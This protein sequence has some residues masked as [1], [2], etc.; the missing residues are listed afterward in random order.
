MP[1][2]SAQ[3]SEIDDADAE[4]GE[5]HHTGTEG[6]RQS[7]VDSPDE[8]LARYPSLGGLESPCEELNR[9]DQVEQ[10]YRVMMIV[11]FWNVA[12]PLTECR[13]VAL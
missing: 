4:A 7:G 10:A 8:L 9:E 6:D 1:R 3:H 12:H 13:R 11:C 5:G 2:Y